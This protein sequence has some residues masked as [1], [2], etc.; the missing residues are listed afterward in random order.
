MPLVPIRGINPMKL[1]YEVFPE[2]PPPPSLQ[3]DSY[4]LLGSSSP[5][6]LR[7]Y[8][9]PDCLSAPAP[10]MEFLPLQR[11]RN[12]E[13]AYPGG[14]KPRHVPASGFHTL[15]PVY[16]SPCLPG[17]FHPGSTPGVLP[18]RGFPSQGAAPPHR[19][20]RCP[21]GVFSHKMPTSM[22]SSAAGAPT[23]RI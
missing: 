9:P 8:I 17:L 1:G 14:S 12:R 20:A 7:P 6:G 3:P 22:V 23:L 5:T 21:P 19:C 15:L 16:S 10:S 4:P 11:M 13:S 18:F 2:L